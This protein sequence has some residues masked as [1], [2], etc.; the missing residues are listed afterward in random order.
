MKKLDFFLPLFLLR[1]KFK[2]LLKSVE[3]EEIVRLKA[4]IKHLQTKGGESESGEDE[5]GGEAAVIE[6]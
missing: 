4:I 6:K 5:A 3:S 2:C 1:N